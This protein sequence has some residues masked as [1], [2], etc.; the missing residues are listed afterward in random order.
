M[1]FFSILLMGC[2]NVYAIRFYQNGVVES[3]C[4]SLKSKSNINDTIYLADFGAVGDGT[5]ETAK[6]QRALN[7]AIGKTL[8]ISKQSRTHYLCGQ[9]LIPSNIKVIFGNNVVFLAKDNLKQDMRNAEVLFRFEGSEN[10]VFDGNGAIFKMNKE[11]YS[12]ESNHIIKVNGAKNI[13]IKNVNAISSGGDGFYIGATWTKRVASENIRF[14]NCVAK[15]NR[16]QG[17]SVTSVDGLYVENC[18]FSNTKGT[19]PEAGVD[20]EP[21]MPDYVLNNIHF[22]SCIAK[23]NKGRGFQVVL[24]KVNEKSNSVDIKFEDCSA[25]GNDIGFS[26]RYFNEH[27]RGL[28]SFVNCT[29]KDS[30]GPGFWELSC[31]GNGALK[32]YKNCVAL[33]N[34]S[35]IKLATVKSKSGFGISNLLGRSVKVLGNSTYIDC[36]VEDRRKQA[37][38]DYGLTLIDKAPFRNIVVKGFVS[39]GHLV[40]D[41]AIEKENIMRNR[42]SISQ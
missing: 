19:L 5:D 25:I 39:K 27:S 38:T 7:A 29:A 10:V 13:T 15:N 2:C 41:I 14:Y 16:R 28:V 30:N 40:K 1:V 4:N 18:E 11:K 34:G 23:G 36:M 17:M 35:N 37:I 8:F 32:Q 6:I 33:N 24:I 3:S 21:S 22:K 26:N 20:I 42:V 31:S 9:L 12:G